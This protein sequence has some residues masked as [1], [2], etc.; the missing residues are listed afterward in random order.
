MISKY[1]KAGYMPQMGCNMQSA[2]EYVQWELEMPARMAD[3][4][5]TILVDVTGSG[6]WAESG[7]W[8]ENFHLLRRCA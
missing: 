1:M 7:Y 3:D 2:V 5:C 8:W 4:N 6:A